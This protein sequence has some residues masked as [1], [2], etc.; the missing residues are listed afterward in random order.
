M[1]SSEFFAQIREIIESVFDTASGYGGVLAQVQQFLFEQFGQPGVYA[2]YIS[3]AVL[4]LLFF[5]KMVKLSF[6][7]LKFMV[8]PAV[9]LAFVGTF[10]L[11]YSFT[12][13]LP[14]TATGCS[15]FLL[16]KG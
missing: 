16:F 3:A 11:P 1:P 13:L 15:I 4:G 14:V 7:A 9:A 2:A 10:F 6:A 5:W 8:V 12:T